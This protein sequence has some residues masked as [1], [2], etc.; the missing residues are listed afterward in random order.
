MPYLFLLKRTMKKVLQLLLISAIALQ[1]SCSKDDEG[2][3]MIQNEFTYDGNTYSLSQGIL[4]DYDEIINGSRDYDITLLSSGITFSSGGDPTGTGNLIYLDLN[5]SSTTSFE[6]GIFTWDEFRGPNIIVDAGLAI[7]FNFDTSTESDAIFIKDG[8]VT[9]QKE[10]DS[11]TIT[12]A[13]TTDDNKAIVG[14]Y[15]GVLT[16]E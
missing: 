7:N 2:P 4:T 14:Y 6:P 12:F 5:S 10:E 15:K 16:N 3:V 13:L 8:T 1:I 11:Y 9:V